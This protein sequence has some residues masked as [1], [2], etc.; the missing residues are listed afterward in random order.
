MQTESTI[1]LLSHMAFEYPSAFDDTL[2]DGLSVKGFL[3]SM[4]TNGILS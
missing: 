2:D 1:A 3:Q 4:T